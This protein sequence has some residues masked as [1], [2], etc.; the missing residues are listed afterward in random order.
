MSA[1]ERILD[2]FIDNVFG[3]LL[4]GGIVI[5]AVI[6]VIAPIAI[7]ADSQRPEFSLKKD[8]WTCTQFVERA[9]TTYVQSGNVM[10]PIT[11]YSKHCTQW[12]E[13][14]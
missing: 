14:P 7:Y 5:L 10:V 9:S 11:S 3:W 8:E 13:K 4:I 2:W 12:S 1:S 6:I